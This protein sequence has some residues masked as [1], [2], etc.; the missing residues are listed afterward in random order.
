M[1]NIFSLR[2][3]HQDMIVY[4][5]KTTNKGKG[6]LLSRALSRK[7]YHPQKSSATLFLNVGEQ[8]RLN[9]S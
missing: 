6:Y 7:A 1:N 5:Y 3:M 4:E 9:I 2:F 8:R